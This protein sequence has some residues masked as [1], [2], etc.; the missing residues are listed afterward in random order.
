MQGLEV[1]GLGFLDSQWENLMWSNFLGPGFEED[2]FKKR[3]E[4]IVGTT[5][6]Q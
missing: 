6:L 5:K 2:R 1:G 3:R 4:T